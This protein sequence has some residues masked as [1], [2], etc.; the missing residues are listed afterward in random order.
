MVVIKASS[1]EF[2][3]SDRA[4]RTYR[5][6]AFCVSQKITFIFALT[7]FYKYEGCGGGRDLVLDVPRGSPNYLVLAPSF[8]FWLNQLCSLNWT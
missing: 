1:T 8:E 2:F 4:S 7:S 5:K 3:R 6:W